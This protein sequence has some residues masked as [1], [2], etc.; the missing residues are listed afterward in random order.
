MEENGP[1][2][3]GGLLILW[4]ISMILRC[5][6]Y[7]SLV[8][9]FYLQTYTFIG[10]QEIF[11]I[12]SYGELSKILYLLFYTFIM[13]IPGWLFY[14]SIHLMIMYFTKQSFYPDKE[15]NFL[16]IIV[17]LNILNYFLEGFAD[18][19]TIFA[20][21]YFLIAHIITAMLYTFYLNNSI[22]VQNT[23]TNY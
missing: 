14:K 1:K 8:S 12:I 3:L 16:W 22:R 11:D 19:N 13:F 15:I 4:S 10:S 18:S 21:E 23:F 17:I 7:F 6:T 9:I 20:I 2:G 5:L